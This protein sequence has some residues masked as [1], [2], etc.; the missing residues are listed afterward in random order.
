MGK[1]GEKDSLAST[2]LRL[3]VSLLCITSFIL[4]LKSKEVAQRT[5]GLG[6]VFTSVKYSD[7]SGLLFLVAADAL[8]AAYCM[9][10]FLG[11]TV[12]SLVSGSSGKAGRWAIFAIDQ[13]TAYILL[14]GVS[15]ASEVLYLADKG[16]PKAQWEA[17]CETYGYFCHMVTASIVLGFLA[18]ILLAILSVLS[19][20]NLF[21]NFYRRSVYLSKMRHSTLT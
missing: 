16:M 12:G 20:R 2:N 13:I 17:M 8:A 5:T 7:S 15:A 10:S 1:P 18:V 11:L 4:V 19:A 9:F 6:T 14:S 3:L 21:H